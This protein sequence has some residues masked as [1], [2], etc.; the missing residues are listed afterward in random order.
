MR[1]LVQ[2]QR[3]A[4]GNLFLSLWFLLP[5]VPVAAQSAQQYAVQSQQYKIAA[6]QALSGPFRV[7]VEPAQQGVRPGSSATLKLVLRNANNDAV[8]ATEKMTL[9]VTATSPS[10][11]AQKQTIELAPGAGSGEIT[12]SPKEAGLWKLDVRDSNNHIKS[13]T[14]YLLVSEPQA[15][16]KRRRSRPVAKPPQGARMVAPRLMLA[17]YTM[18]YSPPQDPPSGSGQQ[19]TVDD[20]IL[21]RVS[22]EDGVRADGTSAA[23]V[24]VFLT[25]PQTTDVRVWLAVTQG[26]L[27]APM[28]TIKAGDVSGEIQWTST[29]VGQG[30]V[31]ISNAS[32]K[33]AGQ[34]KA[35][36]T[37]DF[38]DPIVAI[39]FV[40]PISKMNIVE[41]ATVAVRLVDRDGSPV[42]PHSSLPFSFR[43]NSAHVRLKPEFAQTRPGEFDFSTLVSPTAFGNFTIEAAVAG[44]KPINEPIQVTGLW[45]LALCALGGALG[46]LVKY[47]DRN[48]EKGLLASVVSGMVVALPATWLYVWVGLP[49]ISTTILHNQLSAFM[50]AIIAGVLGSGSLKFAAQKAGFGLFGPADGKAS[51]APA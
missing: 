43:V 16:K 32:P 6:R 27:S 49:N 35:G 30:K 20:G 37:V 41:L 18:P 4:M 25:S 40:Q 21:L 22:G 9:E 8:N 50:V 51:G 47:F 15:K 7:D 14:N 29:T 11:E 31:S 36:A 3:P 24:S 34:E 12:I 38:V 19:S 28:L 17:A 48:K 33:I 2:F 23:R 39:A 13:G 26:Q 45:L 46:G 10:Q 5:A 42:K 1:H 44:Y